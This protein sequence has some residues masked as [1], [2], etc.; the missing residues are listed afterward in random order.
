MLMG[1]KTCFT[2]FPESVLELMAAQPTIIKSGKRHYDRPI[3]TPREPTNLT[4][5]QQKLFRF[6]VPQLA[7]IES[8]PTLS[9]KDIYAAASMI[10]NVD[11][12][13]ETMFWRPVF[14]SPC[15]NAT[16]GWNA[17]LVTDDDFWTLLALCATA[18]KQERTKVDAHKTWLWSK[19]ELGKLAQDELTNGRL[20]P[21]RLVR[22]LELIRLVSKLCELE[23]MRRP[24]ETE[25][26]T[27]KV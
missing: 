10:A 22:I 24:K 17:T 27:V 15:W 7:G 19:V 2:V 1:R 25:S 21:T 4:A 9:K 12:T 23:M 8:M 20:M 26:M 13:G 14:Y 6:I 16:P 11:M 5:P 3:A 18:R